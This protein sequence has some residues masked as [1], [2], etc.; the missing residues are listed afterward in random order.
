MTE[1]SVR[2][3]TS[4]YL[5][6]ESRSLSLPLLPRS[7]IVL[8]LGFGWPENFFA[9]CWFVAGI[10]L[11]STSLDNLQNRAGAGTFKPSSPDREASAKVSAHLAFAKPTLAICR[12]FCLPGVH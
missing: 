6:R 8:L 9:Y 11:R 10:P 1:F 5:A 7:H 2:H 3:L 4:F 12:D